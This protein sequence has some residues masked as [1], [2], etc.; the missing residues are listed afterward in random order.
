MRAVFESSRYRIRTNVIVKEVV[1]LS[2]QRA[3]VNKVDLLSN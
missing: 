1:V 3:N 2:W